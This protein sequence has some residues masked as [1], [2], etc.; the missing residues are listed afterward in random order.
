[1]TERNTDGS[2]VLR[3]V[4]P[5]LEA[6]SWHKWSDMLVDYLFTVAHIPGGPDQI[7]KISM[8]D[9]EHFVENAYESSQ[10]V[11]D[12]AK[13]F[14]AL[15]F[16]APA[17]VSA[18]A[19]SAPGTR[20]TAPARRVLASGT[21]SQQTNLDN[22]AWYEGEL[23]AYAK[24]DGLWLVADSLHKL[25]V[26]NA[27][28]SG[29]GTPGVSSRNIK[30][31]VRDGA[32]LKWA[33]ACYD[34]ALLEGAGFKPWVYKLWHAVKESLPDA[35][36]SQVAS[37]RT[38]DLK[39]L[40]QQLRLAVNKVEDIQPQILK[41]QMWAST[42]EREGKNDTLTYIS[43]LTLNR[44]RLKA[45][46]S[47]LSDSD[48]QGMLVHGLD[49]DIFSTVKDNYEVK[50]ATSFDE[51]CA[52]VK[53]FIVRTK[54]AAKLA[55]LKHNQKVTVFTAAA[56]Q[57]EFNLAFQAF[58]K[59][60][61]PPA[62]PQK[63]KKN[64][65]DKPCWLF[66]SGACLKGTDCNFGH[67]IPSGAK[68]KLHGVG[69][70]D[71][72]CN[73]QKKRLAASP[74]QGS[75]APP[76]GPSD[77]VLQRLF[78]AMHGEHK[79]YTC[80]MASHF[81]GVV[82]DA[83]YKELILSDNCATTHCGSD[84]TRAIPGTVRPHF[85]QVTGMGSVGVTQEYDAYVHGIV[86]PHDTAA[87]QH[88]IRVNGI[89]HTPDLPFLLILCRSKFS[90]NGCRVVTTEVSESGP[91]KKAIT[92]ERMIVKATGEHL[93]TAL[94][95]PDN[96][97]M[98]VCCKPS[99]QRDPELQGGL[100]SALS[101]DVLAF[102]TLTY[103]GQS[104]KQANIDFLPA[105]ES[106]R[107]AP[108]PGPEAAKESVALPRQTAVGLQKSIDD[109]AALHSRLNHAAGFETCGKL[110]RIPVPPELKCLICKFANPKREP[111]TM[112][113]TYRATKRSEAFS[114]DW[115]P[116]AEVS[117]EGYTGY[118]IIVDLRTHYMFF[119][120]RADA[121]RLVRDF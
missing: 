79:E 21:G 56:Q 110:L 96:G 74:H 23:L 4:L 68:C 38:G 22:Q 92:E 44:D 111:I 94:S 87:P 50:V 99:A 7:T 118:F 85:A 60:I 75:P 1:M 62:S 116:V 32:F 65:L 17:A 83:K 112:D 77:S 93:Y 109:L 34:I 36:R 84:I 58:K 3:R 114:A 95:D 76:G 47:P 81:C 14:Q 57:T 13:A 121:R 11:Q 8:M 42:M 113:T 102:P 15:K 63:K 69:H 108:S 105:A 61:S 91:G 48:L 18:I 54:I 43:Y 10:A 12:V 28:T 101:A 31:V 35:M 119:F 2:T 73:S 53:S 6:A 33:D 16:H 78:L 103:D 40:L 24:E 45:V 59:S 46:N 71:A 27:A 49:D 82:M 115:V 55:A 100:R 5:M 98:F 20:P 107:F 30:E 52:T 104:L 39:T 106:R 80:V 51:L 29:S 120:P 26:T 70:S 86:D 37:V 66:S 19:S 25:S 72:E 9:L 89:L 64:L 88:L 117:Y 67:F 41:A 97:L 90:D